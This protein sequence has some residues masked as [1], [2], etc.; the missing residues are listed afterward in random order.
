M[1][2]RKSIKKRKMGPKSRLG[3]NKKRKKVK[4]LG[5][6]KSEIKSL[7]YSEYFLPNFS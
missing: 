4:E 1:R 3:I 6:E 2:V 5:I 7:A